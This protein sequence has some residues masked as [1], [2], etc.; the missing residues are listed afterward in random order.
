MKI[1]LLIFMI[2]LISGCSSK[3]EKT[4]IKLFKASKT[5]SRN[6]QKTEKIQLIDPQ[7]GTTRVLLTST[8]VSEKQISKKM[9]KDETFII[10]LYVEDNETEEVS[11]ETFSL[12]LNR[13]V[14]KSIKAL[15]NT[16]KLLN[17]IPFISPWTQFYLVHFP[18]TSHKKMTFEIYHGVYGKGTAEFAKVAKFVLEKKAY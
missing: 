3:N 8:Y 13:K 2:L 4:F 10:G 12:R 5:A 17:N 16:S 14:P 7:E 9:K 11:L 15:K 1:G 6:L 18:Y